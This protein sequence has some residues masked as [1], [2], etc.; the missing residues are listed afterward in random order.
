M[1][2]RIERV[3]IL[4]AMHKPAAV[5]GTQR[6]VSALREL[7]VEL[8]LEPRMAE[9]GLSDTLVENTE[10]WARGSQLII[11]MGGDG[12]ILTA[13][14]AAAPVGVPVLGVDFGAFG[15]LADTD[16]EETLAALPGLV[17]G[18]YALEER[19][20]LEAQL[21]SSGVAR[22]TLHALNDFV[23]SRIYA[24]RMARIQ[25]WVN[26]DFVTTY[27]ADGLIASTPTGST[28]YNLSAGG[29]LVHPQVESL[30]VVPICSHTLF[31]RPLVV[32]AAAT[33]RLRAEHLHPEE[34]PEMHLVA[35]GQTHAELHFEE[36]I[37][38]T[39]APFRARLVR[40]HP[41]SFYARLRAKLHWGAER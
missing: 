5:A 4:A 11:A 24:L 13:A 17:A 33:L 7:G 8:L 35:D 32:P 39:A 10:A 14:R 41:A 23:L 19:L 18:N 26:G 31:T 29:P 2:E 1:P 16:F 36:E 25:L 40:T 21:V 30:V 12:T 3:G 28:A 20:M 27:P 38:I 15:F 6:L 34:H 37:Q 9:L 22:V